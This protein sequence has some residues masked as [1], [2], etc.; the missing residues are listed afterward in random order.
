MSRV[1]ARLAYY[2]ARGKKFLAGIVGAIVGAGGVA[3]LAPDLPENWQRII[4]GAVTVLAVLIG[5]SN[6][7]K[8]PP[9]A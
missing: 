1:L 9:A 2:A 3:V 4:M 7:P 5:P 6:A 8:Q